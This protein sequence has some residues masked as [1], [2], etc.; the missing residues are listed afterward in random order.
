M[1]YTLQLLS[2]IHFVTFVSTLYIYHFIYIIGR[3]YRKLE[4]P[5]NAHFV[6]I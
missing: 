1:G 5:V 6:D 3:S 2:E 4:I